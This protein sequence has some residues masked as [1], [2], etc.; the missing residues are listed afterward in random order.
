MVEIRPATLDDAPA[1]ARV[2]LAALPYY[3]TD[4]EGAAHELR[5]APAD[6]VSLVAEDAAE[7]RGTA[8]LR[9]HPGEDHASVQVVVDPA[10]RGRG[11]GTAL[12]DALAGD[13]ASSGQTVV[14]SVV[15]DDDSS[16]A[17]AAAWGVTLT[18]EL[19]L[20]SLDPATVPEPAPLP[21]GYSLT[22][23]AELGSRGVWKVF[24]QVVR[25]DPSGLS[26]PMPY[27][28]FLDE[29]AD[30]RLQH[31]LSHAAVGPEGPVAFTLAG[32]AAGRAWSAMTGTLAGHRGRGLALV[33]KQHT[34]RALAEHGVTLAICGNDEAN[35]P[36]LAVNDRLGY[37]PL[38]RPWLGTRSLP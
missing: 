12:R 28:D 17:A 36:M 20:S 16:R 30:P 15:E 3:V 7:I 18:R 13:L 25:D 26:L 34:L 5:T 38:A 6:A 24:N 37:R 27:D 1:W 21:E 23:C 19:R 4:D 11:L 10:H 35:M 31:A 32:A 8:R 2:T 33:L 9:V 22:T 29:W 14:T